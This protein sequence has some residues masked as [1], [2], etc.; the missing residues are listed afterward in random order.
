MLY[1]GSSIRNL[2]LHRVAFLD[3]KGV[4]AIVSGTPNLE[5]LGIYNC[6]LLHVGTTEALLNYVGSVNE[7]RRPGD[8]LIDF[9]FSPRYH[10]G[11][12]CSRTGSYGATWSDPHEIPNSS[13]TMVLYDSA[14]GLA[15]IGLRAARLARK[16]GFELF[17]HHKAFRGWWERIPFGY[18]QSS[19]IANAIMNILD[20]EKNGEAQAGEVYFKFEEPEAFD[21]LYQAM[22]YTVHL[23]LLISASGTP[24]K[25]SILDQKVYMDCAQCGETLH[26]GFFDDS[27]KWRRPEHRVCIGCQFQAYVA[28]ERDHQKLFRRTILG[29]L[30][31]DGPSPPTVQWVL[32]TAEGRA[33]WANAKAM[34]LQLQ[35]ELPQKYLALL[36]DNEKAL[37]ELQ[38]RQLDARNRSERDALRAQIKKAKAYVKEAKVFLNNEQED[39]IAGHET[40]RNWDF[41]RK[42]YFYRQRMER[43]GETNDGPHFIWLN[44]ADRAYN[45]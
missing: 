5:S 16:F 37:E 26:P 12:Y 41:Q 29:S 21:R 23:D 9:D 36:H 13:G 20:F 27:V 17:Q 11:P 42:W 32:H 45:L 44:S 33:N 25:P 2:Q 19:E 22:K 3:V 18:G 1:H 15:V 7:S 4:Q 39:P 31:Q 14:R 6:E 10:L 38:P 24:Q 40:T 28:N 8:K 43:G 35:D 30:W 34:A